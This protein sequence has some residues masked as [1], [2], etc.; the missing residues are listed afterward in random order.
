MIVFVSAVP[1]K[2]KKKNKKQMCKHKKK[3]PVI[4]ASDGL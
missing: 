2:L 1:E 4:T 3:V